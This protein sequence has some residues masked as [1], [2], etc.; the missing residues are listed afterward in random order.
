MR[1]KVY[2]L[3]SKKGKPLLNKIIMPAKQSFIVR[4]SVYMYLRLFSLLTLREVELVFLLFIGGTNVPYLPQVSEW[5]MSFWTAV[6]PVWP[7][8]AHSHSTHTV[9]GIEMTLEPML[10]MPFLYGFLL[11]NSHSKCSNCWEISKKPF[12]KMKWW[13]VWLLRGWYESPNSSPGSFQTGEENKNIRREEEGGRSIWTPPNYKV[14]ILLK[15]IQFN[16]LALYLQC[17]IE[18]WISLKLPPNFTPLTPQ[19][20]CYK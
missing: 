14:L 2:W 4:T 17:Y 12:T 18:V 7:P 19:L 3:L 5:A 9:L 11:E 1:K 13:S 10:V 6:Q 20:I 16:E 15:R 8:K